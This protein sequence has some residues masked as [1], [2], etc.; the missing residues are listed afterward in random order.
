MKW[1]MINLDVL[2]GIFNLPNNSKAKI[3]S[4]IYEWE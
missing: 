1:L 3:D 4:D 2:H